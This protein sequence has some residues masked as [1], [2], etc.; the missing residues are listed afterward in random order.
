M[1]ITITHS[2]GC[3]AASPCETARRHVVNQTPAQLSRHLEITMMVHYECARPVD[4]TL[5]AT[6]QFTCA[7]YRARLS[8]ASCAKRQTLV[9]GNVHRTEYSQCMFCRDGAEMAARAGIAVTEI[10]EVNHASL[11]GKR[12]AKRLIAIAEGK[13]KK[14]MLAEGLER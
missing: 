7:P 8:V 13:R 12:A 11:G 2:C 10:K 3:S 9:R 5:A 14:K 4:G 1:N 6:H